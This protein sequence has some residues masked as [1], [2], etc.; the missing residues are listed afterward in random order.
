MLDPLVNLITEVEQPSLM[1]NYIKKWRSGA[2]MRFKV[3]YYPDTL[4][5]SKTFNYV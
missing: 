4:P 3:P 1:R 5:S 2:E